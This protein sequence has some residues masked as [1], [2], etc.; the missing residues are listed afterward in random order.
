[1]AALDTISDISTLLDR[2]REA[3]RLYQS[4]VDV[5]ERLVIE[6]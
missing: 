3:E 4:P 1:M 2:W 6:K 5:L